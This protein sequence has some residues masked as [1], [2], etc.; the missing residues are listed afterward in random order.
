MNFLPPKFAILPYCT[1]RNAFFSLICAAL[2]A[3]CAQ[4]AGCFRL[5]FTEA[6]AWEAVPSSS[7]F[8]LRFGAYNTAKNLLNTTPYSGL[9]SWQTV[10]KIQ[11]DA[12]L[13]AQIFAQSKC[14]KTLDEQPMLAAALVSKVN[15]FEYLYLFEN[16]PINLA[17]ITQTPTTHH[18]KGCEIYEYHWENEAMMS[19][20]TYKGVCLASKEAFLVEYGIDQLNSFGTALPQQRGFAEAKRQM[21]NK[22]LALYVQLPQLPAIAN[23]WLQTAEQTNFETAA[24][25]T[26]WHVYT[27]EIDKYGLKLKG[28][29]F[30][31]N[32][33]T[34]FF[35]GKIAQTDSRLSTVLPNNTAFYAQFNIGNFKDFQAKIGEN[36]DFNSFFSKMVE[37]S[38]A[39][40]L[41]EPATTD[42][43]NNHILCFKTKETADFE[44]T[45]DAYAQKQNG[46]ITQYQN[47]KIRKLPVKNFSKNLLGNAWAM[48]TEP[49]FTV[50]GE[51]ALFA[52][53]QQSLEVLIDKYNFN[54]TLASDPVFL[55]FW[56]HSITQTNAFVYIKP[57]DRK[58]VV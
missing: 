24:N 37:Q 2:M 27:P 23:L 22:P 50:I 51:Y 57:R 7:A 9:Q 3:A 4:Y 58:S 55:D 15:D 28:L 36:A 44:K 45:L 32:A 5:P 12:A 14:P 26:N 46:E 33:F 39:Y 48:L 53:S 1:K 31:N 30:A 52:N 54:Q 21:E 18:Y 35:D 38:F 42:F 43:T 25:S 8:V 16:T 34:Q 13:L 41:T 20:A 6:T 56:T 10:Q 47:F 19:F 11:R 29:A 49:Y 17:A 40:I